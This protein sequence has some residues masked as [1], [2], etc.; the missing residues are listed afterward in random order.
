MVK[1]IL[2]NQ[3]GIQEYKFS[4]VILNVGKEEKVDFTEKL[5]VLKDIPQIQNYKIEQLVN[6][7]KMKVSFDVID[8][9]SSITNANIEL[10]KKK[11]NLAQETVKQENIKVG[12]NEFILDLEEN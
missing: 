4:K 9:D 8:E 5:E 7:A 6:E 3:A 1:I 2:P 10:R 12:N 11:G